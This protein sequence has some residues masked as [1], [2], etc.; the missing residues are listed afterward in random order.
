MFRFP[1]NNFQNG[2]RP[3]RRGSGLSGPGRPAL[4][5]HSPHKA[6]FTVPLASNE[7]DDTRLL[8]SF[9]KV[10]PVAW[11]IL[12]PFGPRPNRVGSGTT[13][14]G[15]CLVREGWAVYPH[16]A[17]LDWPGRTSLG[18]ELH[19]PCISSFWKNI[20][21]PSFV[22]F[23]AHALPERRPG[24]GTRSPLAVAI[25]TCASMPCVCQMRSVLCTLALHNNPNPRK[26]IS[27]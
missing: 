13:T 25:G 7:K 21:F 2:R 19:W 3:G 14:L 9:K 5:P 16:R 26:K 15:H 24:A 4:Y 23:L 8:C 11:L 10:A 17:G 20:S 27:P 22:G 18:R 6:K 12:S 1:R